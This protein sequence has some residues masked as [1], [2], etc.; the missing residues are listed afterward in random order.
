MLCDRIILDIPIHQ[1]VIYVE[2]LVSL[3]ILIDT[4]SLFMGIQ[5][6]RALFG[7][8]NCEQFDKW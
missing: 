7:A 1:H 8:F 2:D 6:Q 4:V 5:I 3:A